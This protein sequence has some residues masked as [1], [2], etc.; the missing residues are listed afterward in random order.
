MLCDVVCSVGDSFVWVDS[1]G[2]IDDDCFDF[3][4]GEWCVDKGRK[5]FEEVVSWIFDVI[6]V[7]L[8]IRVVLIMKID[9]IGVWNVVGCDDDGDEYKIN[10]V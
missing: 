2:S 3:D 9:G 8:R 10:E 5:K 1:F 6:V 4:E 7:D